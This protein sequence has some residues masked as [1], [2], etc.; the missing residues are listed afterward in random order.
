MISAETL[1]TK[2]QILPLFFILI[3]V[4]AVLGQSKPY[5]NSQYNFSFQPPTEV[6]DEINKETGYLATY[7]CSGSACGIFS[8]TEVKPFPKSTTQ[9]VI[10]L[11]QEKWVLENAAQQLVSN[12]DKKLNVVVISKEYIAYNGRPANK[13]VYNFVSNNISFTGAMVGVYINEKQV[14]LGFNYVA[15]PSQFQK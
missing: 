15:L 14:L 9:E 10:K 3:F 7:S 11:F 8:L 5:V 4:F 2:I 12:F 1:N 13:V 6:D